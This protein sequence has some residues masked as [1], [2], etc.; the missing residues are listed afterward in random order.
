M[1]FDLSSPIEPF[2]GGIVIRIAIAGDRGS[3]ERLAELDSTEALIGAALIGESGGRAVAALSLNDG[4]V[5]AD[6]FVASTEILEL[7]RVRADQLNRA[8]A[9][10]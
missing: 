3:L 6:P 10:R 2:W 5:I 9:S 1:S 8:A 4:K 7:L